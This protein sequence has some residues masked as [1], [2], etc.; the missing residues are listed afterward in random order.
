MH[1][2]PQVRLNRAGSAVVLDFEP[3]TN[4]ASSGSLVSEM[5]RQMN[6]VFSVQF[7]APQPGMRPSHQDDKMAEKNTQTWEFA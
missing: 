3:R 5:G 7:M 6:L 4:S 1:P 2:L